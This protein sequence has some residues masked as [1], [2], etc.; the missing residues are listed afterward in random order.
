VQKV[1]N[2]TDKALVFETRLSNGHG[3]VDVTIQDRVDSASEVFSK[4]SAAQRGTA[5]RHEVLALC[6]H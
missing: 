4:W 5:G 1:I 6:E 3:V 2:A